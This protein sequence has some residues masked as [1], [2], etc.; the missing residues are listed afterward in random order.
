MANSS[1]ATALSVTTL[2][3]F[4][5]QIADLITLHVPVLDY[6]SRKGYKRVLPGGANITERLLSIN[7]LGAT[8]Y[9]EYD[10][11]ALPHSEPFTAAQFAWKQAAIPVS[12]PGITI[13]KNQGSKQQISN[14][15]T[16]YLEAAAI[17]FRNFLDAQVFG[18][19][20]GNNGKDIGG[21]TLL[22]EEGTAWSTVGGIN[23]DTDTFWRNQFNGTGGSFAAVG[24]RFLRDMRIDCEIGGFSPELLITDA[25]GRSAIEGKLQQ[26]FRNQRENTAEVGLGHPNVSYSGMTVLH[27]INT[28][29]GYIYQLTPETIH[30][31]VLK[32]HDMQPTEWVRPNNQ[33]AMSKLMLIYCNMSIRHRAANG[34]ITGL[35]YP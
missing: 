26:F 24:E 18:D 23:S 25:D 15:V 21:L 10:T 6:L 14:I 3:W 16:D 8:T 31:N 30:W 12:L 7:P 34:V 27:D 32:G 2:D 13:A 17:R 1:F 9:S 5:T 22:V 28:T 4:S 33:D 20:T 29:A 19:G 11:I 35:T